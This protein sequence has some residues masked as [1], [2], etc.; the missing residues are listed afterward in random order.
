MNPFHDMQMEIREFFHSNKK[1][2]IAM[3]II[4]ALFPLY[5]TYACNSIAFH[6]DELMTTLLTENVGAFFLGAIVVYLIFGAL[7]CLT[8]RIP[9]AAFLTALVF[10]LMPVIDYF[11]MAILEVH[12]FPWDMVFAQNVG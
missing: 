11:K 3:W 6:S 8:K 4:V 10:I 5:L 2:T 9:L 1:T 12:F 7:A